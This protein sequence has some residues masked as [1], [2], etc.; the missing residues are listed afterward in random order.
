MTTLDLRLAFVPRSSGVIRRFFGRLFELLLDG[1]TASLVDD[2]SLDL[3]ARERLQ[4]KVREALAE[5]VRTLR[6]EN[7]EKADV[8]RLVRTVLCGHCGSLESTHDACPNCGS[9]A[10]PVP[11]PPMLERLARAKVNARSSY[12]WAAARRRKVVMR[13]RE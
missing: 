6:L 12:R 4:V 2:D 8:R 1:S 11:H 10:A 9:P 13:D 7:E 3:L 5:Y